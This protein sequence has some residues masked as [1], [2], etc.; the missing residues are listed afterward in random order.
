[1]ATYQQE[2]PPLLGSSVSHDKSFIPP[3]I[4]QTGGGRPQKKRQEQGRQ[5]VLSE[6]VGGTVYTEIAVTTADT[7]Q[8]L[9]TQASVAATGTTVRRKRPK[10]NPWLYV[11]DVPC[12]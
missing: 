6:A 11:V 5:A 8:V 2:L 4:K 3:A 12:L 7:A 9:A 1:V 10:R